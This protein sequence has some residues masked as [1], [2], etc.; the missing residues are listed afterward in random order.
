MEINSDSILKI[1]GNVVEE[2]KQLLDNHLLDTL[3]ESDC[4][5]DEREK[6]R[7]NL[8]GRWSSLEHMKFI[9][10]CLIHGNCWNKVRL[11]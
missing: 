8:K 3:T 1:S 9:K 10:G 7:K 2:E 4:S 5:E 11:L 6:R